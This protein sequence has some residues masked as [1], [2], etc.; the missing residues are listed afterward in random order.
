MLFMFS[1]MAGINMFRSDKYLQSC[2][3]D[4]RRNACKSQCTLPFNFSTILTKIETCPPNLMKLSSMKTV[5][6]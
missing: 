3:S 4:M 6:L 5:Q 1:G 2:A